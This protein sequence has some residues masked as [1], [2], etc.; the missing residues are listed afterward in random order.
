MHYPMLGSQTVVYV[1]ENSIPRTVKFDRPTAV[2]IDVRVTYV[3]YPE[4]PTQ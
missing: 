4:E 2:D 1:D 3:S